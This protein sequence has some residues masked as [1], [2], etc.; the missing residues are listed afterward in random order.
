MHTIT[1]TEEASAIALLLVAQ[2]QNDTS[3]TRGPLIRDSLGYLASKVAPGFFGMISIP[4]F[5]R[6]IGLEEY[7]RL[8]VILPIL[9]ALAGAGA[10]WV[11]QGLLRFHPAT[12]DSFGSKSCFDRAIRRGTTYSVLVLCI[13]L[14]PILGALHYSW[15]L[16]L[17][18]ETYCLVQLIYYVY[19]TRLQAQLRPR[20]VIKN[21][22]F[23]SAAG[24][25]LPLTLIVVAGH[26][27]FLP[28]LLGLGLAY[29]LPLV[30]KVRNAWGLSTLT[31]SQIKSDAPETSRI[32][33]QLWRFGWAVGVWLMLCQA[34][35]IVGRS[36]IKKYHGYAQAGMY[37]SLYEVAVRSF[38]L[39][40]TPVTQ[41]AHPRIMRLWNLGNHAQ[42][43][44]TLRHAIGIQILMFLPIEVIGIAFAVPITRL[45]LGPG[46]VVSSALLPLL[47]L[48][49]FLWQIAMLVH[50]PLEIMQRT[51]TMLGAMLTVVM[52]EIAGNYVLVSRFG[53]EAAVYVFVAGAVV[54]VGLVACLGG[55]VCSRVWRNSILISGNQ[56]A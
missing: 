33:S 49:G 17:I 34:L 48:G 39:L 25:F 19:L 47:M 53:M 27:S 23:R 24:F 30:F 1:T 11:Q 7:G 36:A 10:G 50:K 16:C 37:A 5:V 41:A 4:V 20:A 56:R 46:H 13:I 54:Y 52:V 2:R 38:S 18:A 28:V 29:A 31:P 32:L 9:M 35:P 14:I 42:A 51:K 3:R 55:G 44:A 21:E 43:R 45:I 22:V 12:Q 15:G 8:S 26:R 40:A 6:L